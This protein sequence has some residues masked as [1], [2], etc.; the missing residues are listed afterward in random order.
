MGH[1]V[2]CCQWMLQLCKYMPTLHSLCIK[3]NC[4]QNQSIF[5]SLCCHLIGLMLELASEFYF[6][7]N[8][9]EK[10]VKWIGFCCRFMRV[11][12]MWIR[13]LEVDI[14]LLSV[15]STMNL[16]ICCT[17]HTF[18]ALW[19][20]WIATNLFFQFLQQSLSVLLPCF[21]YFHVHLE[22]HNFAATAV[23]G[24]SILNIDTYIW[25]LLPS[26]QKLHLQRSTGHWQAYQCDLG[27]LWTVKS[28]HSWL[29]QASSSHQMEMLHLSHHVVD[30]SNRIPFLTLRLSMCWLTWNNI[31]RVML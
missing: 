18:Y 11:W 20:W 28:E 22:V 26:E 2:D 25:T 12:W 14:D 23:S 30:Y 4:R 24:L 21:P 13:L 31:V 15:W 27:I 17:E 6:D 19:H 10:S 5:L 9:N 1:S 16:E 8:L 29:G 3:T 7:R